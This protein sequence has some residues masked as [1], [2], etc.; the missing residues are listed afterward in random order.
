MELLKN[1]LFSSPLEFGT[2]IFRL[3]LSTLLSGIIGFERGLRGRA[4]GLRTH[5][6]V[7]IGATLLVMT[8][9]YGVE[10]LG[11]AADPMRLAAQVVSGIGF[12]GAGTIL[13]RGKSMVMGLTTAAGLWSTAAI[14]IA[15]GAGFYIG[16]LVTA[17]IA[18]CTF[19]FLTTIERG[20]TYGKFNF[21]VYVEC[22]DADHLQALI[23]EL[24]S[25]AFN[26]RELE[27]SPARSGLPG[28]IGI[29][30]TFL[31]QHNGNKQKRINRLAALDYVF[32]AI[33]SV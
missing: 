25:E 24:T 22:N 18:F 14:G 4:A 15:C 30:G 16:A 1:I 19:V 13:V 3:V 21:R 12:L 32:I 23:T 20:G 2:V 6:L 31:M 8:G 28:H 33:E 11:Y 29:E 9:V 26:L 7:G 5:I 10:N 17:V 27:I